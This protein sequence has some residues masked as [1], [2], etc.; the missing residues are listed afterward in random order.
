VVLRLSNA[1]AR[2]LVGPAFD[3]LID[4]VARELDAARAARSLR[5]EARQAALAR[6][7]ALDGA[8]AEQARA[9]LDDAGRA[10][11]EREADEE[12]SG[13]RAAMA[14][15]A[16]ARA[17]AAAIDRLLRERLGLPTIRY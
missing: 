4:R 14:P 2:G 11:L 5:G 8:L 6:L 12:L 3:T 17:R 9:G 15:E 7:E 13:Y 1:R 16:Y 10:S